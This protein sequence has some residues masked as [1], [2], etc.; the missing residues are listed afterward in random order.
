MFKRYAYLLLAVC[1]WMALGVSASV[2]APVA[3]GFSSTPTGFGFHSFEVSLS[4][5]QAGSHPD[6]TVTFE[7]NREQ[8]EGGGSS[9][10]FPVGGEVRNLAIDLPPGLAGNATVVPQCTRQ[11]LDEE[12]GCPA[13][14]QI[15]VD[16]VSLGGAGENLFVLSPPVY[17][18]VPPA[19]TPVQL[20]FDIEHIEVFVDAGIRSGGDNG[21]TTRSDNLPQ[22]AIIR[23]TITIFG[24]PGGEPFLTLPTSCGAPLRFGVTANTWEEPNAAV[25]AQAETPAVTGCERLAH[26]TPSISL[27]PDT[28]AADS[29]AGLSVDVR[30]PQGLNPE[31]LSTSNLKDTTVVLPAGL[32]VNPGRAAGSVGV[33]AL[34]GG[35][36]QRNRR[37][38]ALVPG[39]VQG[40]DGRSANAGVEGQAGW[41]R[42]CVAVEPAGIAVAVRGL[43]GWREPEARRECAFGRSDG[44]VDDDVLRN[45][46]SAVQR[47]E[48]GVRRWRAG[49]AGHTGR[50]W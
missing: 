29:P 19:G 32:V 18:M 50:V 3:P 41:R 35:V 31:G 44:P 30:S 20:A 40:R 39:R 26:F 22:R 34:A 2:A 36:G 8:R 49:R 16:M 42:I 10:P 38:T 24:E 6:L 7:L 28:S 46:R 23:N 11:Q 14:T 43:R 12:A 47:F 13:D 15:G 21:I 5:T 37:R 25:E 9:A 1:A 27:A 17:N 45:T 33:P 4:G 48:D